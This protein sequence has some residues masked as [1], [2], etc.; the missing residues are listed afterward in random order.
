M[1]RQRWRRW[2]GPTHLAA[3]HHA[4]VLV[5][6]I[7][8]VTTPYGLYREFSAPLIAGFGV[9]HVIVSIDWIRAALFDR[10]GIDIVH[11]LTVI[12]CV[13]ALLPV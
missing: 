8:L 5:W 10:N 9:G 13:V 11:A 6:L 3:I 12:A 1:A 4:T 7:A 2:R